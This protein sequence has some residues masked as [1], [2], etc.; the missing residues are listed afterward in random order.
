MEIERYLLM[1]EKK[2]VKTFCQKEG[3]VWKQKLV[4]FLE[5]HTAGRS[6]LKKC[7]KDLLATAESLF[8][9]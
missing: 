6:S 3:K 9:Q 8:G 7:C 4:S 2:K 5:W 1:Y